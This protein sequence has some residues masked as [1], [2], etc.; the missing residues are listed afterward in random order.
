MKAFFHFTVPLLAIITMV[1]C[2][3]LEVSE[4]ANDESP[5]DEK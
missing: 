3:E 1:A 5:K 4:D 2:A